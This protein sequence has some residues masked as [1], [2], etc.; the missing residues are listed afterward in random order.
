MQCEYCNKTFSTKGSLKTHQ[1][2]AKYCIRA[3]P[4]NQQAE[5]SFTCQGCNKEYSR[6]ERFLTHQDQ[7]VPYAR[8]KA[9]EET[10]H[11]IEL[12]KQEEAAEIQRQKAEQ[13]KEIQRQKAEQDTQ[14][15][16]LQLKIAEHNGIIS[17]QAQ[18]NA[19]SSVAPQRCTDE[20]FNC[21]L[22]IGNDTILQVPMRGDGYVNATA[23]CKAGGK[24][25]NDYSRGKQTQ[26]YVRALESDT[27]VPDSKLIQIKKGGNAQSQGT[28][29]HP[30]VATHLAQ[31][32]SPEFAV[33]V[34]KWVFELLTTGS[35]EVD[36]NVSITDGTEDLYSNR[37]SEDFRPFEGKDVFYIGVFNPDPEKLESEIGEGCE[38]FKF[39][40]THNIKT[41]R[42][43]HR[44]NLSG[45]RLIYLYDCGDGYRRSLL[46]S[47]M[48]EMVEDRGIK[49]NY[50]NNKEMFTADP[51]Q[52]NELLERIKET[53]LSPR[54]EI[55]DTSISRNESYLRE[56]EIEDRKHEREQ[57]NIAL[58]SDNERKIVEEQSRMRANELETQSRMRAN[59]LEKEIEKMKLSNESKV[60]DNEH[61]RAELELQNRA[62]DLRIQ[63]KKLDLELLKTKA[64]LGLAIQ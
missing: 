30:H 12:E 24:L 9:V 46:E 55:A 42:Q 21:Q 56:L 47:R 7:C 34:N 2:T 64:K 10:R 57:N 4:G 43:S 27:G 35:A 6:R 20:V 48:S 50:D 1:L 33:Q 13:D 5:V 32:I 14:I 39:G 52:Y 22:K 40:V 31:W 25:F 11:Q 18:Q 37:L 49:L 19:S 45:F 44:N 16:E 59:E 28:W 54:E 38:C 3:Q 23:L 62:T 29:V 53:E 63:E 58:K 17:A 51:V 15:H 61:K 36:S 60:L 41:R 8:L 26:A